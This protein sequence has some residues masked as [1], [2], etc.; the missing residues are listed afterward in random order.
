MAIQIWKE[1]RGRKEG[2]KGR[3]EVREGVREGGKGGKFLKNPII[4]LG[5]YG[6]LWSQFH[7]ISQYELQAY[8]A[9]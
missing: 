7:F 8:Q 3:E 4:I 5:R 1:G 6:S 2:E 9:F